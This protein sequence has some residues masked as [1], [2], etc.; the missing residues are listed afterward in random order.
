VKS[1]P[2]EAVIAARNTLREAGRALTN[3]GGDCTRE[4]YRT[5]LDK[6]DKAQRDL[7]TAEKAAEDGHAGLSLI[8]PGMFAGLLLL[9]AASNGKLQYLVH[10]LPVVP[11]LN[12]VTLAGLIAL[13]AYVW[14]RLQRVETPP[15]EEHAEPLTRADKVIRGPLT[16]L[17][18]SE[19]EWAELHFPHDPVQW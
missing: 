17:W 8:V 12:G 11:P 2:I 16:D 5:L 1:L 15:F 3:R 14:R 7:R 18:L 6:R 19:E 9:V 4:Q 10:H 13:A